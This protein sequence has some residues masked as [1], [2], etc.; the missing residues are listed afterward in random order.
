[1]NNIKNYMRSAKIIILILVALLILTSCSSIQTVLIDD[2]AEEEPSATQSEYEPQ[3]GG[4]LF[5]AYPAD[6][7]S[8]DPLLAKN[9][10]LINMLS[11]I[12]ETPL[13]VDA[14]GKIQPGLVE[15]WQVDEA[16]TE[17]TFTVRQGVTFHNGQAMTA[18]DLFETI[19]DILAL[20]GTA[21]AGHIVSSIDPASTVDTVAEDQAA[22][23]EGT[24]DTQGTESETSNIG[25]P[26]YIRMWTV[27]GDT[28]TD[29]ETAVEESGDTA[30]GGTGDETATGN[31]EPETNRFAIYNQEIETV[32]LVDDYTLRLKMKNPG[33]SALYFM[34]FPVYPEDM[35]DFSQPVG[36]GPYKVDSMG[37]EIQMS[38]NE[39]WWKVAPYIQSITAKPVDG[40]DE[41]LESYESG[42]LDLITT[43]DIATNKLEA[44]GKSQTVD[45]LTNYYDCL[46]PNLFDESM[47]NDNV[48][49]AIS[50]AINRRL[51]IS[52]VLLNHAVAAEM[53]ISPSFFGFNTE[54]SQYEYDKNMAKKLLAQEGYATDG[55]GTGNALNLTIIVPKVIGEEYKVESAREI[56]GDL[57][58]VGIVCSLEE[59]TPEEYAARLQSGTYNLAYVSYYLDQNMDISFLFTPDGP[60]N[61]GHVSSDELMA[62]IAACNEAVTEDE[63][64]SAYE[65]LENYFMEKVPQIGL[66]FRMNS[67]IADATI[68][69]ISDLY[70]NHIFSG[71]SGW[72]VLQNH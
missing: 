10:D 19:M 69:G 62:A 1:M 45:Y 51:I 52:T 27:V 18:A 30:T 64:V 9:E 56:A 54:Y 5:I 13:T 47:K 65:T 70:E 35:T 44:T 63:M 23:D 68:M 72:S 32:T 4:E 42:L 61:F 60:D 48:R 55:S 37:E 39:N 2:A 25:S 38:V 8:F 41:K 58:E 3:S 7:V 36:T 59:L 67:M 12:Y 14:S 16:K 66:Y 50:Y 20:D 6:T 26:T 17:F 49:K 46:V 28:G 29:N 34:T 40:Q 71:I 24:G 15:T 31:E 43:D 53:P 22:T 33:R 11:L 57:S 21:E